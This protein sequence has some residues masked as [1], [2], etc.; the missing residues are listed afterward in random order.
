MAEI[1]AD[2]ILSLEL[3]SASKVSIYGL[4]ADIFG[5]TTAAIELTYENYA[6]ALEASLLN[7][8]VGTAAWY[9]AKSKIFQYGDTVQYD[10]DGQYSYD[11]EDETKQIIERVA[12]V[13]ATDSILL[14]VAKIVMGSVT[15]LDSTELAAFES[16]WKTI[17][18]KPSFLDFL[19][20]DGDD[21]RFTFTATLDP[22]LYD[23]STGERLAD[24]T[25]AVEDAIQAFL[26][27]Y[28]EEENFDGTFFLSKINAYLFD[29]LTGLINITYS[30]AEAKADNEITYTDILTATGQKYNSYAGYF[31]AATLTPNYQ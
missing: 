28:T 24:G 4:L 16:Y 3:T 12:V 21:I 5:E 8:R 15:P 7:Q 25:Q 20:A 18:F 14:K 10:G 11:V 19:S 2:P 23:T 13:V 1:A 29:N 6:A 27:T 26:E 22:Q 30:V 17:D 31:K 9:S